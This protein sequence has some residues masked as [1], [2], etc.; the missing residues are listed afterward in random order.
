MRYRILL[1]LL[2]GIHA[3]L[4]AQ[5]P[6]R[7]ELFSP[8]GTVKQV[9]QARARFSEPMVPFADPRAAAQPFVIDCAEKG[10]GRWV[11]ARNWV[12]DFERDLPAGVRCEFR[13]H[14]SL[15]TLRGKTLGGEQ[16]FAFSTGGPAIIASL[17]PEGSQHIDEAQIFILELDG[18]ATESSVLASVRFDVEGLAERVGARIVS[19]AERDQ[20]LKSSRYRYRKPLPPLLLIQARQRF[21]AGSAVTLIWGRGVAAASGVANES[22]LTRAFVTR[23]PFTASLNCPREN[24]DAECIPI[25]PVRLTFSAPV[26]AS[27]ARKA[28]V[29][30]PGNR[31]WLAEIAEYEKD[32]PY[33]QGLIFKGPFPE[34]AAFT[35]EIPAGL[36][37]E[38]GRSLTNSD[39]FPLSFRSAAYPSLAKFAADFGILEA[40]PRALLPVTLRNVEPAVSARSFEV[41]GGEENV[42]PPAPARPEEDVAA[43]LSGRIFR[44]PPD[45]AGQML[46]WI[47]K[48]SRRGWEDRERSV[49][50]PVTAAKA[51]P[52]TIPKLNGP[53]AFEVVGI[54]LPKPGFYVVEIE[55]GI[56]GAAL[57]GAAKPMFVPTAVL[58]TNLSVHFKWGL[59]SSLVWITALDTGK[60]VSQAAV[61][62]R[63]C[64]G[65]QLWVGQSDRDGIA[66]VQTLPPRGSS[67]QCGDDSLEGGLLVSAQLGDDMAFVHSSWNDGIEPWRF[68]LPTEYET[69]LV[70]AHTIF[71]RTL[72][73]AGETV[74]MKHIL[75]RR[76]SSGFLP[77]PENE[78]PGAVVMTHWGSDQKYEFPLRWDP[79]GIAETVWKIPKEARLG[80]YQVTLATSGRA[81][82]RSGEF[83]VEEYRVPLMKGSIQTP[84]RMLVAPASV[85][86]DLTV[87]YLA[88]GAAGNLPVRLRHVVQSKAPTVLPAFDDFY[89]SNGRVK[90]GLIRHGAEEGEPQERKPFELKSADL[91]VDRL[92]SARTVISDL[93]GLENPM[94]ILAELEFRDPNGETQTVSSRIPLYPADRLVGIKPASWLAAE[95]SALRFQVAVADLNGKPIA[96]APVRVDLFERK[97]YSHRKRLVGGFYAFE[98]ATE[99][100]RIGGLCEGKTDQRGLLLCDKTS[101]ISGNLILQAATVDSAGRETT[102]FRD[103]WVAGKE[104]WWFAARD[105]DRI[106]VIP[107]M[108]RYEPGDKARFQVRMPF[109][110]ATAL[111]TVEREGI[112]DVFVRELQGREPIVEV[113][114]KGNFAP[115][116]FVSV[117][118]VRGRVGGVQPTAT[119]DL[120]RPA[121][122]LGIAE[123][124]V[125]WKAHELKV[126]VSTDRQVYKVREK[127]RVDIAVTTPEGTAP[128]AGT[129]V[130]LAAVDEGLLELQPNAS[131]QL[132][133][134]MMRRRGCGVETSTAQMHVIGKR[135][136]GLKALPQGGGGGKQATREL[137]DT[138]LL[139]RA[140]V[141]LDGQGRASVE[142]PLNDS[143]TSFRIVA[144]ATGA[145]D[146]FGTGSASI[147][148]TQELMILSGIAPVV[149]QGDQFRATFTVRNTTE[150]QRD[151][152]VSTR[153]KGIAEP[154]QPTT[155]TLAPGE[156][157]EIAWTVTAPATVDSLTYE[158]EAKGADGAADRLSVAQRVV[159]AVPVRPF[160]SVLIPVEGEV[161]MD[162]ERPNDALP[163]RGGVLVSLQPSLLDGLKGVADYMRSYPYSCLEQE[164]SRAVAL[165]D[166]ERW[167]RLMAQLP[168]YL[169]SNGLAKYFPSNPRGSDV[170][171]SY[172]L[173]IASEAGWQVPDQAR[174]A[175]TG[176]LQGFVEGRVVLHSPVPAADLALRKLSALNA[177]SR[178]EKVE[179]ALLSAIAIE[180][181]L[182]PTSAVIDWFDI[183]QRVSGIR[184]RSDRLREADQF[185]RSRLNFQGT[186]MGF[187]TE[188]S[189][190]LWWLM[191]SNDTNA[192]RLLLSVTGADSWREDLPRLVRGSLARQRRG[193]WD[194]TVANA[195]GVLAME[196]FSKALENTSVT[197]A[198]SVTLSA[199]QT[200]DWS[201]T[202]AGKAVLFPWPAQRS[203]L[204]IRTSGAGKPWATVQ[205]L[206]AIPLKQPLTSGFKLRKTLTPVEQRRPGGW[207]RGDVIRV[208]IELEASSDMTWVVV[209]DPIPGGGAILG[210]GLGRDSQL[211]TRGE[212]RKGWVW[213]AF[214]E[215]SAEAFR[216]YY[217][218][219][220]KGQWTVEYT[221]RLNNEGLFSLPP[222]RVEAMYAPEM[223]G[224]IPNEVMRIQ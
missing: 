224:E 67:P 34:L 178:W 102:A 27:E 75:R 4:E 162:L 147:R 133:D 19:G 55:S 16:R 191:V 108:K 116:V 135:H 48:I 88:G 56:L 146:R 173:A 91:T 126:K 90:E 170:L 187:S 94:E 199:T 168:A 156:A 49:F 83:R 40:K 39:K 141:P 215:R 138:L 73:R 196:R 148:S 176:G 180:P 211:L 63:D 9:R 200:V 175:M 205:S 207:S 140:R 114:V 164:I 42:D 219:V 77:V 134:A 45:R 115:N 52:F 35:L 11:D 85:P 163:G 220:P 59:E 28:V 32:N 33:V 198:T 22:D 216:A 213:P 87:S 136:F 209:S 86:L 106:D 118:A 112:A 121:Y 37:D 101:P 54:P 93:P 58:A 129:E 82:H 127:A 179:P 122:K 71:D 100:R 218:Y 167:N 31:R 192:V 117:L 159:P 18:E 212:E 150:R 97:T 70:A 113:P 84:S 130:A 145:T 13:I 208:R 66:R 137:F 89:F 183:L 132:I 186:T 109:R 119:V 182:W 25:T 6:A 157:R 222:T 64:G 72:L 197:G 74:H 110:R 21:P 7:V 193:H 99:T 152:T 144:V 125:G 184:N 65:K 5:E 107:E 202:P 41:P 53:K 36:K 98:H 43:K 2:L 81:G 143:L 128:P 181:N 161:R 12:Y 185:L 92:G 210:T 78:R 155:I 203:P 47:K 172:F 46:D 62:I 223:F 8:Q 10:T 151:A 190:F 201:E 26:A 103:I 14:D 104:D 60:P 23:T 195:W 194:T 68:Q 169:D 120:G 188:R 51:E 15:R 154:L 217:E 131:W 221:V 38:S 177:L 50:G 61:V 139:W 95:Q 166:L 174:K 17:P 111:V 124:R 24:P 158:V 105:S 57:L 79:A 204:S 214:E 149:R 160:Q 76:V 142:V 69:S 44:V 123:I 3:P 80:N 96:G 153:V 20:I 206:A 29:R 189:D 1:V 165:R 30:G 171:T